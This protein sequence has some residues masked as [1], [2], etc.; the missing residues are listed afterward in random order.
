MHSWVERLRVVG[1][2]R[3]QNGNAEGDPENDPMLNFRDTHLPP[4]PL[5]LAHEHRS[6]THSPSSPLSPYAPLTPT[7]PGT[8]PGSGYSTPFYGLPRSSSTS[9]LSGLA[10]PGPLNMAPPYDA[11]SP[12]SGAATSFDKL[13]LS[14]NQSEAGSRYATPKS[15]MLGL[16]P[17][18]DSG[19]GGHRGE[20]RRSES[21]DGDPAVVAATALA[22]LAGSGALP[23]KR[24]KQEERDVGMD[25]DG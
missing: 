6:H 4:L 22:G 14:S 15:A 11:P 18:G 24:I 20:K 12:A 16:P 21:D 19:G 25:V 8:A 1:L 3:G 10:F 2:Q 17:E 7:T 23:A 5:H 13:T 9:S